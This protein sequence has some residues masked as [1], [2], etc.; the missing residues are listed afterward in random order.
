[1]YPDKNQEQ[2]AKPNFNVSTKMWEYRKLLSI[3]IFVL[4]IGFLYVL[5]IFK[6]IAILSCGKSSPLFPFDMFSKC[7]VADDKCPNEN[8]TFWLYTR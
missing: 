6:A 3:F 7:Y 1:M 5:L 2:E 8:V 4:I